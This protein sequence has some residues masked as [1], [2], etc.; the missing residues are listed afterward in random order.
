V[1]VASDT[2]DIANTISHLSFLVVVIGVAVAMVAALLAAML[3]ARGLR[4]LRRLA[5]GAAES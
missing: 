5:S 3:T 1:L 2:T 4:P